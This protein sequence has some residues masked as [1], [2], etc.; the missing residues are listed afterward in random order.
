MVNE[1]WSLK[2]G[3]LEY[4]TIEKWKIENGNGIIGKLVNELLELPIFS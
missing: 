3:K 1:S 2:F 4:H